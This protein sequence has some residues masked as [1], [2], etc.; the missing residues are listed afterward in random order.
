[1]IQPP[2]MTDPQFSN[3]V[4]KLERA[5]YGLKQGPRAWFDRFSSFLLKKLASLA[6]WST[7]HYLFI[8]PHL[9]H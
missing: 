4:C 3:H 5:L 6:A 7:L 2:D 8:T 1:M 9:D